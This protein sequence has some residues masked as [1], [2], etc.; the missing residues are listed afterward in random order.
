MTCTILK[1][2]LVV[3][4]TGNAPRLADVVIRSGKNTAVLP[5]GQLPVADNTD[6]SAAEV[7]DA[8]FF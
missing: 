4:G 1:N 5:S 6:S 2:G 8:L 3:D 7:I